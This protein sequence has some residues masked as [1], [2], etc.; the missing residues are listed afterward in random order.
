MR[1]GVRVAVA[2]A[3][4]AFEHVADFAVF[5]ETAA[6]NEG[7]EFVQGFAAAFFDV[8]Q[9]RGDRFCQVAHMCLL[10]VGIVGVAAHGHQVGLPSIHPIHGLDEQTFRDSTPARLLNEVLGRRGTWFHPD[11]YDHKGIS[12]GA[13]VSSGRRPRLP[14]RYC[15]D[16][17]TGRTSLPC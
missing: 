17:Q 12:E 9:L 4:I 1:Q 6:A 13:P 11:E 7:G 16:G 5:R 15:V 3:Q 10:Q 8:R 14:Q 2:E